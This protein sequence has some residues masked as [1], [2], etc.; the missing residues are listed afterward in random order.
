MGNTKNRVLITSPRK[1]IGGVSAFVQAVVPFFKEPIAVF[2]R[3]KPSHRL[4]LVISVISIIIM[5]IRFVGKLMFFSPRTVIVN[6]SLSKTLLFRD[7][8]IVFISKMCFRKVLLI[9]HGFDESALKKKRL[10]N[11]GYFKSDAIIVLSSAFRD[12]ISDVGFKKPISIQYNP[13]SKDIFDY[14]DNEN[15]KRDLSEIKDILYISR[16]EKEKGI[17]VLIDSFLL[18]QKK[19]PEISLHIA[20]NGSEYDAMNKYISIHNISGIKVYGFV[21]G[22]DKYTLL[23]K[24]D[25]LL[26]PSYKEGLPINVL[27]S[28]AFGQ[29]VI[30]RPIG[31]LV[32]L[33]SEINFGKLVHSLD[34]QE[35]ADAFEFMV[36]NKM[37]IIKTRMDNGK[38]AKE[39]FHPKAIVSK[40]EDIICEL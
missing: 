38:F 26:F 23:S 34:P 8:I 31:G 21:S 3:G 20:G 15:S 27:E 13:V 2:Y 14:V 18:I 1:R 22:N 4:S 29:V 39:H 10:I 17:Y 19:H 24:C 16:I 32:D 7:G 6:T 9:I 35:Y 30:T 12:M 40:M 36:S 25:M 11:N 33:F 5:P 28:M 37:E